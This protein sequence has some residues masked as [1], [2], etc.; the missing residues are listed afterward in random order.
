M[1]L[2]NS[3]LK[4]QELYNRL[5]A[6]AWKD[7]NFKKKLISNPLEAIEIL[8]GIQIKLPDG[9]NLIAT[10][11]T[12]PAVIYLNIPEEKSI[13][14]MELDEEQLEIIAGGGLV[15]PPFYLPEV[16]SDPSNDEFK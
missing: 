10:D 14:D 9:K 12:N 5:V 6:M 4:S 15:M 1:K 2:K 3:Q 11:Q 13:E 8:T 7:E 16:P